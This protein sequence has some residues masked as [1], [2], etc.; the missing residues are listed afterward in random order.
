MCNILLLFIYICVFIICMFI[1]LYIYFIVV[2]IFFLFYI[3]IVV[4]FC[5]CFLYYAA[6]GNF[7]VDNGQRG[8]GAADWG[9]DPAETWAFDFTIMSLC[10]CDC[11][12]MIDCA[13]VYGVNGLFLIC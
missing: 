13:R 4:F 10:I 5:C 1:L 7:L 2:S 8:V 11:M 9:W 6:I 12:T 3:V